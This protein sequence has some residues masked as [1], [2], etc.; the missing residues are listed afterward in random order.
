MN[1]QKLDVYDQTVSSKPRYTEL[2]KK[3]DTFY[4]VQTRK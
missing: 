1:K 3:P 2:L 4:L